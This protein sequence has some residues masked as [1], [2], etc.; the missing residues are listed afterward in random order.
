MPVV[1]WQ[2]S[3]D[4]PQAQAEAEE[5]PALQPRPAGQVGGVLAMV[6]VIGGSPEVEECLEIAR[7]FAGRVWC[8]PKTE[9]MTLD[10]VVAEAVAQT[11][12]PLVEALY[13]IGQISDGADEEIQS[14]VS[15]VL[16]DFKGEPNEQKNY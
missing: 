3:S 13:D 4:R 1:Y 5:K 12:L 8:R 16:C 14:H 2:E 11:I 15:Q 9:N 10:P 7:G 6:N